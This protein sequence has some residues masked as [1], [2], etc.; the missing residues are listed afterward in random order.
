MYHDRMCSTAHTQ[1]QTGQTTGQGPENQTALVTEH[2]SEA[3]VELSSTLSASP[4]IL[5]QSAVSGCRPSR[6]VNN[7][8]D[9]PTVQSDQT[10]A[11]LNEKQKISEVNIGGDVAEFK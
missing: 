10:T 11:P 7:C 3:K 6:E 4:D 8:A 5:L 1:K 9:R 2:C